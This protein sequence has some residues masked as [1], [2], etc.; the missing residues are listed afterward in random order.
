VVLATA[1]I[2]FKIIAAMKAKVQTGM[3]GMTDGEAVV[4]E[5]IVPVGRVRFRNELWVATAEG[6]GFFKGQRVRI[7]D[8][9]GLKL[10]VGNSNER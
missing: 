7:Q 6:K 10:I 4:V 8:F 1:F 3:E 5:D 9:Q 2:Y